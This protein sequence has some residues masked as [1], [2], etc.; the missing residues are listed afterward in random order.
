MSSIRAGVSEVSHKA[1]FAAAVTSSKAASA[2]ASDLDSSTEFAEVR[3]AL[4]L[5][6]MVNATVGQ[7]EFENFMIRGPHVVLET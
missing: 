6:T 5:P 4:L 3:K 1:A 2:A 7:E